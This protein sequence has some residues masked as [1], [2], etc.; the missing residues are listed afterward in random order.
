MLF[1]EDGSPGGTKFCG[2]CLTTRRTQPYGGTAFLCNAPVKDPGHRTAQRRL[3][4][5]GV[6]TASATAGAA[7]THANSLPRSSDS[8][9]ACRVTAAHIFGLRRPPEPTS[10]TRT[11]P[12]SSA[13]ICPS[14]SPTWPATPTA[15]VP[16]WKD[17]VNGTQPRGRAA[18]G[19]HEVLS[20]HVPARHPPRRRVS[21]GGRVRHARLRRQGARGLSA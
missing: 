18:C 12:T 15:P 13:A 5:P 9:T 19:M 1:A 16:K 14:S 4:R 10:P 8:P 7:C 3:L 11:M 6:G 2:A 17:A 21:D 20:R